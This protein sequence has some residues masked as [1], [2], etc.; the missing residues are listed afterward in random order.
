MS[1]TSLVDS[2]CNAMV[3]T[4]ACLSERSELLL[5]I[6]LAWDAYHEADG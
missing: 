1:R 6:D 4:T 5:V 2:L 3:Q